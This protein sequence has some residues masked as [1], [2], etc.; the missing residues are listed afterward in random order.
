MTYRPWLLWTARPGT[1]VPDPCDP[2]K[3]CT[4]VRTDGGIVTYR[5][6]EGRTYQVAKVAMWRAKHERGKGQ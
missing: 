1:I 4:V 3:D 5:D 6:A 2:A